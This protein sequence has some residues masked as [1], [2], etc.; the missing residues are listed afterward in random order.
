MIKPVRI[1]IAV[2]VS[3]LLP[4]TAIHSATKKEDPSALLARAVKSMGGAAAVDGVRN[5]E[6]HGVSTRKLPNGDE[7]ELTTVSY[8]AFPDC[9]RQEATVPLGGTLVTIVSPAGAFLQ[10]SQ[11]GGVQLPDEQKAEI[12]RTILRNP[13]AILQRRKTLKAKVEGQTR[14]DG[15]AAVLLRLNEEMGSTTL[16]LDAKTGQILQIRFPTVGGLDPK[17]SELTI[18]Y[19]DYRPVG[20]LLYPHA[21][22][23]SVDDKPA[24]SFRLDSIV[25]NGPADQS[26]FVPAAEPAPEKAIEPAQQSSP[27]QPSPKPAVSEE[28]KVQQPTPPVTKPN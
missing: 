14:I 27:S 16:A 7:W 5:L 15:K 4:A 9:Y 3:L 22:E 24:F 8:L 20:K 13:V 23:G 1:V 19:S 6:L 21:S 11:A 2:V 28:Q 12:T 25:V 10:T 18:A 17:A 26:L